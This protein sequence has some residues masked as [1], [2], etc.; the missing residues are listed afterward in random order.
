MA[1]DKGLLTADIFVGSKV[2]TLSNFNLKVQFGSH[3][4]DRRLNFAM[5]SIESMQCN[6]LMFS[7]QSARLAHRSPI[8]TRPCAKSFD[9]R[10][11][12]LSFTDHLIQIVFVDR[13]HY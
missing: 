11:V 2:L 1:F 3:S 6:V 10:S 8:H 7:A 4:I 5:F 13:F 9:F 12:I